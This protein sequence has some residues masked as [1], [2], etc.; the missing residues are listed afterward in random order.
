MA[1]FAPS[2]ALAET[3]ALRGLAERLDQAPHGRR[4]ELV[5]EVA[6]LLRCSRQQVYRKLREIGWD[7]GRK[8]RA[9]AGRMTV[10]E[11]TARNAAHLMH[12]ATRANGKRTL[13]CTV[14][15][16]VLAESGFADADVSPC[17][18]SRAMRRYGCHPAQ[19]AQG[20]PAVRLRSLHPNHVW[21][22]DPSICVIFYLPKGG[23]AV[24]EES[25][26]YKNKDQNFRKIERERV[27]RYVITDHYSGTI[28]VRYVQSAGETSQGLV[29]VFLDAISYRNDHDPMHGVPN[30]LMMDA[31]S[32]NTSHL[33]LNLLDR[34]GV[35]HITHM[36]GNARAKGSVENA[37]NLVETQ[38]EGRLTFLHVQSLEELQLR[39]DEW[40]AHWNARA[41]HSRTGKSRADV[42]MSI[43]EAQLRLAP[44]LE[45]CRE[46]V[47]TRP[48]AATV[49]AD[50]SISHAVKGYGRNQY[51]LRWV[52]GLV[53]KMKVQ[54]VVNPY[55]APAVDV[56]LEDKESGEDV[57]WTV[58]PMKK[59]AAG[60]WEN[61]P[62]IGQEHKAQPETVAD[63]H[64][65]AIAEAAGPD[66]K[67]I[68]APAGV[69]VMADVR[70]APQ[71]MPRR[72]RDL[73]LDAGRREIQPLPLVEAA[74][75]LKAM[76]GEA[77]DGESYSWLQ[78]RY[79]DGVPEDEIDGIAARITGP[80]K[81]NRPLRLVEGM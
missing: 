19:L 29:D 21:Q 41:I 5:D 17:T 57:I 43:T 47:T 22:V 36:P 34:L 63:R 30:I 3:D 35:E 53:P 71:Y 45:L 77:W 65:K 38:F 58:E 62:V 68:Q 12:L 61:A 11:E 25:K 74:M 73:T 33:F 70:E 64:I 9:D 28:Y 67:H 20:K 14:A 78:Q 8:R 7:S 56:I 18:L 26:F 4:A 66:P 52:T 51:D 32:A 39:A 10:S 31:G 75:R 23:L 15:Q 16:E 42:W 50:M 48:V 69:N 37:N 2:L 55:R 13:P 46:L 6:G 79:P 44:D 1:T 24:M 27:W 80:Q 76:V 60:F 81:I 49:G 59:D 72:G 54:V 40:R